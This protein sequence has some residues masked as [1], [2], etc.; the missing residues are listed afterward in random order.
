M[1]TGDQDDIKF[2]QDE[3][4][5][6]FV[7]RLLDRTIAEQKLLPFLY[8]LQAAVQRQQKA[9]AV[10]A[11]AELLKGF[12]AFSR[13]MPADIFD[14]LTKMMMALVKALSATEEVERRQAMLVVEIWH[15]SKPKVIL[16]MPKLRHL[17]F[18]VTL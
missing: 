17:V 13:L 6:E 3:S 9:S 18:N 2:N 1:A 11:A 14:E 8:Q 15:D 16:E 5:A 12:R 10:L 7:Q 4:F